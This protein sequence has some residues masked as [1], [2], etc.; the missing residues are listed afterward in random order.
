MPSHSMGG[1]PTNGKSDLNPA[2]KA[3]HSMGT[4]IVPR[5]ASINPS[6]LE[7]LATSIIGVTTWPIR[8]QVSKTQLLC[9]EHGDLPSRTP[10]GWPGLRSPGTR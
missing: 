8:K 9:A 6:A 1:P 2:E 7:Y 4:C 10:R 3:E 5:V